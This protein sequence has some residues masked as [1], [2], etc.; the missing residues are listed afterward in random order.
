[1]K[2]CGLPL[3]I[4]FAVF[5]AASLNFCGVHVIIN[6]RAIRHLFVRYYNL[7]RWVA[8]CCKADLF[9]RLRRFWMLGCGHGWYFFIRCEQ[10]CKS[11]GHVSFLLRRAAYTCLLVGVLPHQCYEFLSGHGWSLTP[12]PGQ[13]MPKTAENPPAK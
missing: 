1:M 8:A 3:W 5:S 2:P 9:W 11:T 4:W 10:V 7:H 6:W 12:L 13:S